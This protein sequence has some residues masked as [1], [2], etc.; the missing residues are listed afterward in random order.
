MTKFLALVVFAAGCSSES[1]TVQQSQ[2][3]GALGEACDQ[4][5]GG[6]P[7]DAGV[8]PS[9]VSCPSLAAE[10]E[11]AFPYASKRPAM[12][13]ADVRQGLGGPNPVCFF[14]CYEAD[15]K[16]LCDQLGGTCSSDKF[17]S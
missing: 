9:E 13:C 2:D 5:A 12:V 11:R 8:A 15:H 7:R 10:L 14:A 1:T 17:C 6:Q 16:A 4:L 3:V